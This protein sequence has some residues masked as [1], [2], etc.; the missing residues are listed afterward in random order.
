MFLDFATHFKWV[1]MTNVQ[2]KD[3]VTIT[4]VLWL[5]KKQVGEA[6]QKMFVV[7]KE[8]DYTLN[9]KHVSH[10]DSAGIT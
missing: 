10:S 3:T 9:S 6:Q 2:V 4:R 7:G 1:I 8:E 5:K